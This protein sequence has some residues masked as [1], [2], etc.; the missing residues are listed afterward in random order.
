MEPTEVQ[1]RIVRT[2]GHPFLSSPSKLPELIFQRW[3]GDGSS[4]VGDRRGC[5]CGDDLRDLFFCEVG[6]EECI[7]FLFAEV[8]ALLDECFCQRGKCGKSRVLGRSPLTNRVGYS[9]FTP[10]RSDSAV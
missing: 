6:I 7:E 3:P 1:P 8:A 2:S 4:I 5:D 9:G 10:F